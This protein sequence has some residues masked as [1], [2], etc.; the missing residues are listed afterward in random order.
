MDAW[1]AGTTTD[2]LRLR[3]KVRATLKR[4]RRL[5]TSITETLN[6]EPNSPVWER[7]LRRIETVII[8]L[9][10]GHAAYELGES[11]LWHYARTAEFS[12]FHAMDV[13]SKERYEN[14]LWS[15]DLWPEVGTRAM[16]RLAC[17]ID[18]WVVVQD[19][20]YRYHALS[21]DVGHRV[22]M[23]IHEHFA[24]EVTFRETED[25]WSLTL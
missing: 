14:A 11:I 17:G 2:V 20:N 19:G 5:A 13:T 1:K 22:R 4:S 8:K 9:A 7:A 10:Q 18:A 24:C 21:D 16:Q 3:P 25:L 6:A 12:P 23:V 15:S